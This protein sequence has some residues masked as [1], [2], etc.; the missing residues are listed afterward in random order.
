MDESI[1]NRTNQEYR[2]QHII[3]MKN[4]TIPARY[5]ATNETGKDVWLTNI[6]ACTEQELL[7]DGIDTFDE[8][9]DTSD[10]YRWISDLLKDSIEHNL[11]IEVVQWSLKAMKLNPNLT[12]AMALRLGYLEW[13]K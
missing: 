10:E 11:E 2:K 3:N 9:E 13:V 6:Y 5:L 7:V 1:S 4:N 12:P 8:V